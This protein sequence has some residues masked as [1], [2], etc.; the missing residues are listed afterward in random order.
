MDHCKEKPEGLNNLEAIGIDPNSATHGQESHPMSRGGSGRHRNGSGAIPPSRQ[1]SLG[2]GIPFGKPGSGG[3]PFSMGNFASGGSKLSSEE[4]FAV[5]N[6]AASVAG[7]PGG[8]GGRPPPM[9]R[10]T[11]QGGVGGTPMSSGRTRSKR[12][13][14]RGDG[15][16]AGGYGGHG[17]SSMQ[18]TVSMEPVAPL[19]K[20]ANRWDRT[21]AGGDGDSTI[22][23]DR[24]VKGLL[25]K[26]TMDK[27]D[28]ISD[29]L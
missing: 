5:S 1:A 21:T 11:S 27:F 18:Q 20:S 23:V 12:G 22:I 14:K 16:K 13:E 4:R 28:S 6:R 2:L 10:S 24:K 19:E 3:N 26:L 7:G 15:N 9:A 17:Q 25:N 29:Q 8:F